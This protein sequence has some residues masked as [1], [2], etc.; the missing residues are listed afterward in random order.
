MSTR[1]FNQLACDF[2]KDLGSVFPEDEIIARSSRLLNCA[3]S[4]NASSVVPM[5]IFVNGDRPTELSNLDRGMF[6]ITKSHMVFLLSEMSDHNKKVLD[7][8]VKNMLYVISMKDGHHEEL[9]RFVSQIKQ[10]DVCSKMKDILENPQ[11]IMKTLMNNPDMLEEMSDNLTKNPDIAQIVED[12]GKSLMEGSNS[13]GGG[14]DLMKA[15][16]QL[17]FTNP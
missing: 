5:A 7:E 8:Y 16:T 9:T 6:E 2:L 11:D 4:C 10:S 12:V 15:L 3:I 17:G 14:K 13:M 1:A